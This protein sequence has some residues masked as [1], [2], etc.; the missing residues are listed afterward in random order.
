MPPGPF[1]NIIGSVFVWFCVFVHLYC[2]YGRVSLTRLGHNSGLL[3]IV[4]SLLNPP[5]AQHW[6]H[7]ELSCL[8][9]ICVLVPWLDSKLL[10]RL[11]KWSHQTQLQ[12]LKTVLLEEEVIFHLMEHFE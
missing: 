11:S 7:L 1:S 5:Q 3:V 10:V 2:A 6:L 12:D 4:W 9:T 8:Q